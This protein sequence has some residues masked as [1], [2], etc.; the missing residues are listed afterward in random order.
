M[1]HA[2]TYQERRVRRQRQREREKRILKRKVSI[3]RRVETKAAKY[4]DSG[5][6]RS[7]SGRRQKRSGRTNKVSKKH[8]R[9]VCRRDRIRGVTQGAR[10]HLL[11]NGI[12]RMLHQKIHILLSDF[13]IF[14]V[15]LACQEDDKNR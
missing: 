10:L 11:N 1:T 8:K 7:E 5:K 4:L 13:H 15:F 2:Y 14:F 3:V 9:S 6:V 12:I